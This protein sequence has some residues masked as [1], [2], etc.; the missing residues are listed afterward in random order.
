MAPP[1]AAARPEV[2]LASIRQPGDAWPSDIHIVDGVVSR[3]SPPGDRPAGPTVLDFDGGYAIPGLWDEHVHMTQWAL[4]AQRLDLS[5]A[6]SARDAVELLRPHLAVADPSTTFVG[7]GFRDAVWSDAPTLEMLDAQTQRQPTALLSHDLHCVWLNS[8]AAE[9]YGVQLEADGLLREDAAFAVTRQLDQL[10][11]HLVDAW[12]VQA[13]RKAASRGVVGIVDFEMAWNRDS[14]IRREAAGFD[15]LRVEVGVYAEHLERAADLGLRTGQAF[16]GSGLLRVGPV[17]V[18]IDG[19]LN[20]R[21]AFCVDPYPHGGKGV[22]TVSEAELLALLERAGETGFVPAVHAIGDAANKVALDAFANAGISGRIEHAQFVREQDFARFAELHVT[23]SVQPLHALD[24]RDAAEANWAGHTDRAFPLRSLLEAG[25]TLAL[26]SDAPVAPLDPWAAMSAATTRSRR[27][28]REPWHPEQ[29][30]TRKEALAA[31]ARGRKRIRV[32]DPA[33]I[34]I[35]DG[36]PLAVP[37]DVFASMP[38]TA[39]VV[40]GRCTHNS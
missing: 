7:V 12:V 8:A 25:A 20:T 28:G 2:V 27:D 17:K 37:D 26:G 36:N 4:A 13:A 6:E 15:S 5:R 29:S 21:T 39:T 33:D 14:W 16:P 32:G 1:S 40:G 31:S 35:L 3:I 22:L 34:A 11:D 10:P 9:R 38:V 24:D 18:L 23:A 19:S 30:I